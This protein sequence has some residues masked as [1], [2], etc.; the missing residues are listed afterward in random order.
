M[1]QSLRSVV[2]LIGCP[3][4]VL[5]PWW[6]MLAWNE[7]ATQLFAGWLD[8]VSAS[9]PPSASPN[10]L[11]FMFTSPLART[12]V[13]DWPE[14][15][16][17]VVAEFRIDYGRRL[18]DPRMAALVEELA[19]GSPVFAEIWGAQ[20]VLRREGGERRF[21][22]ARWGRVVFDQISADVGEPAGLKL[23]MLVARGRS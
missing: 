22:H 19:S 5:D 9:D 14:R 12:L 15:A 20:Q 10:L 11:R 2:S 4:Y 13:D 6:N 17:R 23:V 1:P 21:H 18:G 8:A 16:R 3:A 7:P